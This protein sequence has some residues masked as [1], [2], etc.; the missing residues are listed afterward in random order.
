MT[1]PLRK[2]G[3]PVSR[4]TMKKLTLVCAAVVSLALAGVS[5]AVIRSTI[6]TIQPSH[7]ARLAGTDVYCLNQES[8]VKGFGRFFCGRRTNKTVNDGWS[9]ADLEVYPSGHIA[10]A[11]CANATCS[12]TTDHDFPKSKGPVQK[13]GN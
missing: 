13:P 11:A 9:L 12:F 3:R 7:Y 2:G 8:Q 1:D 4:K 5:G 10:V 6:F